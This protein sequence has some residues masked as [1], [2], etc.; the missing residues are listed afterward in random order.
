MTALKDSMQ[1]AGSTTYLRIYKRDNVN[2]R[3]KQIALDMAAL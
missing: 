2:A 3:Y 1:S